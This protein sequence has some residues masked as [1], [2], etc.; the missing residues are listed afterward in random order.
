MDQL[1]ERLLRTFLRELDERVQALNR[2]LLALEKGPPEVERAE[3]FVSLFRT[4]HSLKGAA[5][6][7]QAELIEAA[8]HR[9]EAIFAA[10]RDGQIPPGAGL[11]RLLFDTADAIHASGESL[12]QGRPLSETALAGLLPRLDLAL[13]GEIPL[14]PKQTVV[15]RPTDAPSA[16]PQVRDAFVRIPSEKL[17]ALLVGSSE[18]LLARG[19]ARTR[20]DHAAAIHEVARRW[21]A[22]LRDAERALATVLGPRANAT[23]STDPPDNRERTRAAD[24]AAV[25]LRRADDKAHELERDLERLVA[26]I[27]NDRVLLDEAADE[28]DAEV[29]RVRMLPFADSCEGVERLVR[30]VAAAG[31]K[32]ARVVVTGG[33]V[34]LDRSIL[35][36]LKD[37]LLHLVR[38]AV[39]HG[40]EQ[41]EAR[42]SAGKPPVGCVTIAAA[43]NGPC[44]RVVV[45]DDGAGL[46]LAAIRARARE[47][48]LP[49]DDEQELA[50]HIFLPGFST[51]T[52]ITPIS[53]RGVGLDA[54]RAGVEAMRGT[55]EVSFE[56]GR[57]TR[58]ELALP[59][60]LTTIRVV[61]VEAG[62]G[63]FAIDT[64]TV[65]RV[66]RTD[67]DAW[68]SVEGRDVLPIGGTPV[69]IVALAELLGLPG[70]RGV[71]GSKLP[72]VVIGSAARR[73][74]L[75]V[76][77]VVGEQEVV[78]RNLGERLLR[79][80]NVAGGTILPSGRVALILHT[81]DLL[82]AALEGDLRRG[83]S[84]AAPAN[85]TAVRKRIL[86]ADDSLTTRTLEKSILEFAGYEVVTAA[87]G[88]EAWR[89]LQERSADLVVSDVEMPHLD[90]FGL[91][92]TIRGSARFRNLPVVL[93]SRRESDEDKARGLEAGAD[94]YLEKSTFDQQTLL[95]TL[96]RLL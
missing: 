8:A 25:A 56:P 15:A 18:L 27:A 51:S 48:G 40:I 75:V 71:G 28:L 11:F 84:T 74:A 52:R 1:R 21:R 42:R 20:Q 73:A 69:P 83:P 39:D 24:R 34:E 33:E 6:A 59:L 67:P 22:E 49:E 3:L 77:E 35:D 64:A 9:L 16:E 94:A 92:R 62:G 63:F 7:I 10:A 87:D 65:L 43:L 79:V 95:D 17:D 54:V 88:E 50:R 4:A 72:I 31:R 44:I 85:G 47:R 78:V 45:A 89:L 2:A 66:A 91:T 12:S 36:G 58:F 29:R 38:N 13:V 37:P 57:G 80:R 90:G 26:G 55:I 53:G 5:G 93:V 86:I 41:P 46:D 96:A 60:T 30:D 23:P 70:R 32:E 76:D 68:R 14:E 82:N 19:R 61:L 81:T